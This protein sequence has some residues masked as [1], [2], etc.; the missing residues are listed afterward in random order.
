MAGF[1]E[2]PARRSGSPRA[3]AELVEKQLLLRLDRRLIFLANRTPVRRL[4]LVRSFPSGITALGPP[5]RGVS[6]RRRIPESPPRAGAAFRRPRHGARAST[7]YRPYN[8][9]LNSIQ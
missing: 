1:R 6:P 8:K 2:G 5:R 4:T 7:R 9:H 3:V